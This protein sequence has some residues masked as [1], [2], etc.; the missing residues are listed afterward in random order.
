MIYSLSNI[1]Y[2]LRLLSKH[3]NIKEIEIEKVSNEEIEKELNDDS[4]R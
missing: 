3:L 4:K 1:K 2:H